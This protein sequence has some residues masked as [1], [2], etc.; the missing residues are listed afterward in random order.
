MIRAVIMGKIGK[1]M[2]RVK[3]LL[4]EYCDGYTVKQGLREKERHE[5]A[6]FSGIGVKQL[7]LKTLDHN[8]ACFFGLF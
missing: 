5:G 4:D 3:A 2:I 7:P 8:K 6:G 1:K